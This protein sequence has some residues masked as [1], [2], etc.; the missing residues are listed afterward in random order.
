[1]LL[2]VTGGRK[3]TDIQSVWAELDMLHKRMP[4]TKLRHGDAGGVDKICQ[5]W[6]RARG[7]PDEPF[8]AHWD[9]LHAP[10]AKIRYNAKGPYNANAGHYRNQ[11]MLD[12]NPKPD[13]AIVFPG[14][15]GTMDMFRRIKKSGIDYT[16]A[17]K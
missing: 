11:L 1:M 5:G 9:N 15:A 3:Y 2:V 13:H 16:L 4:I 6:A 14:G 7:I 12:C 17:E 10:D 8:P